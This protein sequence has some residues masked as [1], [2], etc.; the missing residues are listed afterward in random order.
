MKKLLVVVL[1]GLLV[2]AGCSSG[3]KGT[4]GGGEKET[5]D[6]K[7]SFITKAMDSEFWYEMKS[8]A[9]KAA[10]DLGVTVEFAAPDVETNVERQFNIIQDAIAAKYDAIIVAPTDSEG[11]V[12]ILQ[13]ALDAEIIV[14]GVDTNF[15]LE[16]KHGFVGT[17]NIQIGT[18]AAEKMYELLKDSDNKDVV[19]ITGVPGVQTMRD[20]AQGF[21]DNLNSDLKLVDTQPA[22]S[23]SGKALTVM[24]NML[25][26]H[27]NVGGLY[28]L[29]TTMATGALR[30]IESFGADIEIISVDTSEDHINFVK[31]D[32]IT[33]FVSQDS[34]GMGYQSV[35]NA[36]KAIKGE[37]YEENTYVEAIMV[38]K[39]N[40]DEFIEKRN[41]A[42]G[43][44]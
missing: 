8:G 17:D 11:V 1:A 28:V 40:L 16:G 39:E 10:E 2:L 23:D 27:P 18:T 7:I 33:G 44:N 30:A 32:K 9:E 5:S 41:A 31:E 20:R 43:G 22:D 13:S 34:Y 6:I 26:S 38:T 25:T 29:N 19:M 15:E 37:S 14:F 3:N 21:E 42:I 12:P 24:E 35:T 4:E 36:V